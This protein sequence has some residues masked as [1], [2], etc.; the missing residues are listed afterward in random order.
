[1]IRDCFGNVI[2]SAVSKISCN[3]EVRIAGEMGM[4]MG[5]NLVRKL[6]LQRLEVEFDCL[7]LIQAITYG[8]DSPTYF[9]TLLF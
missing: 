8:V 9:H 6:C 5:L 3:S 7:E 1:M 4:K 2:A